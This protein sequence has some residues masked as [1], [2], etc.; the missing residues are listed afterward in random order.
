MTEF[1][2]KNFLNDNDIPYG[3]YPVAN[4]ETTPFKKL[5]QKQQC[6]VIQD[7]IEQGIGINYIKLLIPDYIDYTLDTITTELIIN[8]YQY[9]N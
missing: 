2:I 6:Q 4:I 3:K 8:Q 7:L 9:G 1:N 5:S